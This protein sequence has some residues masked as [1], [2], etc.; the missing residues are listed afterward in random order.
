VNATNREGSTI[1]TIA[2]YKKPPASSLLIRD[3][4]RAQ[5]TRDTES[6]RALRSALHRR[7]LRFRIGQKLPFVP[8]KTFDVIFPRRKVAVLVDGC[9]WHG[10]PLHATWPKAN[11][12]WW[13]NK[14]NENR[15]RD[16]RTNESLVANGWTVVRVWE[17]VDAEVAAERI[18]NV[19][20]SAG[21]PQAIVVI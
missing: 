18:A 7:G 14:L 20:G 5:R 21:S 16:Q 12:E 19:L 9:F 15:A 10:C 17:H 6:E 13:E 1:A 4:M 2:S 11:K 3:R 8:R